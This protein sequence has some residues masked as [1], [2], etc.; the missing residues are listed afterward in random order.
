ML[1]KVAGAACHSSS[2][3]HKGLR[4]VYDQTRA[5]ASQGY[6]KGPY[7]RSQLDNE[8][9]KNNYRV[10]VRF[11]IEQGTPGKRKVRAIDNARTALTNAASHT[12][13]TI[14]CITFEVAATV[15]AL[16]YDECVRLG[17]EMLEMAIGFED[18]TAAYRFVPNSQP[19]FTVF[20][21]WRFSD[22]ECKATPVFYYTAKLLG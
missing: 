20:C 13:E 22:G 15:S 9:G 6:V 2:D 3:N 11:G 5:E 16:V 12:H 14:V 7:N 8:F 18:L 21:V 19:N 1:R 17:I 10:Q 4:A